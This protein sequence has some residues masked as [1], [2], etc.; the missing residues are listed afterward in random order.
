[1]AIEAGPTTDKMMTSNNTEI[2]TLEII[3]KKGILSINY[4]IVYR[5]ARENHFSENHP[6]MTF[7]PF[8]FQGERTVKKLLGKLRMIVFKPF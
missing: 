3:R 5:V 8:R 4:T 2:D 7:V 6:N 1:M